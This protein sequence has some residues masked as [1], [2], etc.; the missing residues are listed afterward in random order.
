MIPDSNATIYYNS[1]SEFYFTEPS[2]VNELSDFVIEDLYRDDGD[3]QFTSNDCFEIDFDPIETYVTAG[4]TYIPVPGDIGALTECSLNVA[5]SC[6]KVS[7]TR[8]KFTISEDVPLDDDEGIYLLS[9]K[10]GKIQNP[11]STQKL[12]ISGFRYY[13]GCSSS[14]PTDAAK[15]RISSSSFSE[16]F[17]L[18]F[19]TGTLATY[20]LKTTSEVVGNSS[21]TNVATISITPISS[22]SKN[23]GQVELQTPAWYVSDRLD[24]YPYDNAECSSDQLDGLE[25]IG[26]DTLLLSYTALL[27]GVNDEITITCKGWRNPIVPELS[28]ASYY[29][30]TK[31]PGGVDI[32]KTSAFEFDASSFTPYQILD[33]NIEYT[34]GTSLV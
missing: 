16:L 2:L 11:Y 18:E 20:S 19:D 23:G 22:L 13:S 3:Y 33:A 34:I 17:D 9:G 29:L 1:F 30:T 24:L 28:S 15:R 25:S 14:T 12:T 8:V 32:D 21:T 4:D 7:D 5:A 26:S 6:E 10:L 27:V 31:D